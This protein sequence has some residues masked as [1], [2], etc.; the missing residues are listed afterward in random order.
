MELRLEGRSSHRGERGSHGERLGGWQVVWSWRK[1]MAAIWMVMLWLTCE[2]CSSVASG[3][4]CGN[5]KTDAD[6]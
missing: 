1:V 6:M 4:S 5:S 2:W 3:G